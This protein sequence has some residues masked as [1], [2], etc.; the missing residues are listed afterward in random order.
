MDLDP[1]P[2][3][4]LHVLKEIG[5]LLPRAIMTGGGAM[6]YHP[7]AYTAEYGPWMRLLSQLEYIAKDGTRQVAFLDVDPER[8][9]ERFW[10]LFNGNGSLALDWVPILSQTERSPDAYILMDYP[11]Y[12]YCEGRTS[13]QAIHTAVDQLIDQVAARFER[14]RED[15]LQHSATMGF[16]LG[17]AV[18]METAAR[19]QLQTVILLAPF[20]SMA[21]MAAKVVGPVFAK[22]LR[23]HYDNEDALAR[24]V[25]Q[26]KG[27][28]K[29]QIIHG[30]HDGT[31]PIV[32]ARKLAVA[33]PEAVALHEVKGAEHNDVLWRVEKQ[34]VAALTNGGRLEW[35]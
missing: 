10:F 32:M 12:G 34:V 15:L 5:L 14:S 19:Y 3:S 2:P 17:A 23:H 8:P 22:M 29:V 25:E 16:S 24:W 30:D 11:G 26:R 7:R 6:I 33:H 1:A 31:V 18:A 9:P 28:S 4:P 35:R 21:H 13:P 20:T 27:E